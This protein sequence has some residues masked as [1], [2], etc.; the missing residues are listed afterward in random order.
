MVLPALSSGIVPQVLPGIHPAVPSE[1][2]RKILKILAKCH[3]RTLP[4]ISP[5]NPRNFL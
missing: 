5:D 1:N 3:P 2:L 4:E